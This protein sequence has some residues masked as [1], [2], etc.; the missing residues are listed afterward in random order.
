MRRVFTDDEFL[1]LLF[2]I[3]LDSRRQIL[4]RLARSAAN[5]PAIARS[6]GCPVSTVRSSLSVMEQAGLVQSAREAGQR[7]FRLGKK[8]CVQFNE[9]QIVLTV[10]SAKGAQM[11]LTLPQC[12]YVDHDD[13]RRK[14]TD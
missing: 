1:R 12:M 6:I 3:R 14:G 10:E 8:A 7:V 5:V 11:A 9:D 13:V 4:V 2:I